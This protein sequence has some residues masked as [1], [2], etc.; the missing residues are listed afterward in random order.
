MERK[1]ATLGREDHTP[2]HLSVDNTYI[3]HLFLQTST[4][5]AI[6]Y[7]QIAYDE[8][9]DLLKWGKV[10]RSKVEGGLGVTNIRDMNTTLLSRWWWKIFKNINTLVASLLR[11][12]Y[13]VFGTSHHIF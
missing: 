1:N 12:T 10:Y 9:F 13:S 2:Q 7:R 5:G 4:M 8:G 3:L 11:A 6:E